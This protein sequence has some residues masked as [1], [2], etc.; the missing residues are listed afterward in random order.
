MSIMQTQSYGQK[1]KT[2]RY[3]YESGKNGIM[4]HRFFINAKEKKSYD[5]EVASGKI[6]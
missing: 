4:K 1:S 5:E 2:L 3:W 6:S